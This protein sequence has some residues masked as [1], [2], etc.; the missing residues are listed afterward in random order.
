MSRNESHRR[1]S[2]RVSKFPKSNDESRKRIACNSLESELTLI[3]KFLNK[4]VNRDCECTHYHLELCIRLPKSLIQWQA[5]RLC[6]SPFTTG[7]FLFADLLVNNT[8]QEE[9][10][11]L[12]HPRHVTGDFGLAKSL[13]KG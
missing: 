7:G 11:D 1:T 12:K 3:S 13:T 2:G 9:K 4:K 5:L 6:W 10:H 8:E